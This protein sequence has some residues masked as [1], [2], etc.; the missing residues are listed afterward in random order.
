MTTSP[1][2]LNPRE[3]AE[4]TGKMMTPAGNQLFAA[5]AA[6][7]GEFPEIPRNRTATVRM[8]AGGSY[9]YKYADLADVFRAVNPVLSAF[10]VTIFQ[11]IAG[12][13]VETILA[14]AS[15]E[16]FSSKWPIKAM[17]ARGLDDTQSFQSA[18]QV[19]K[20][21]ALTA[22]LGITTEESVEGD[23]RTGRDVQ[24]LDDKFQTGD[25]IRMPRGAKMTKDMT[26]RQIA[27]ECARAIEAQFADVKTTTGVQGVWDRNEMFIEK[28]R[29][30]H[31]DLFSDLFDIWSRY[32]D[33]KTGA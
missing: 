22:L 13:E 15:G 24:K 25:G 4:K 20:R 8:K 1:A 33:E 28:L 31:S 21:Y 9:S 29:E 17:P 5:L 16:T 10:G 32:M 2:I 30:K 14:H 7:R 26:P 23:M 3:A 11:R 18:V 6:A 27:E 19:A 12:Q